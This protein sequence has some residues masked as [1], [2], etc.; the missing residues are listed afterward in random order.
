MIRIENIS[1]QLSHRILFI[2]A[3]AALNRGEKIGLVGPNGAGKTSLFRMIIGHELPDEGQVSV[4]KGVSIGYFNQDV[5]EMSGRSAVAEVMDGAGPVS[6]V[7]AELRELEAAMVDPDRMDEMD[8]IIERY[9]EVQA[10]YEELDGYA[11]DGRAREVLAGLSFSEAMMDGDVGAL[12]GGWKMRVALARILL[13]RPDVM[14]LDEPS[15]H[16]D[17]E[18]LIWLEQ[19]L[20]GYEGAL[21][22]TSHDREFMNR[23]VNKIIEIDAGQL[24]SYSGDYEFYEGQRAQNEKQ[25]QAQFERQQAMLA[26][27]IKFIERFKARA[28]HASQVQSRVKKLEKI[29]RVEPPKRRQV[30]AFEFQP[31]PRSGEDVVAVK[32]VSKRYGDKVIYDGFDFMVRRKERWCIMGINGAGKSTLLKLVAGDSKPDEGTVSIGASVK[33]GYFAQH[34]MDVLD[35]EMTIF[36]MLETT[37]PRAGQAPLRALAGC[38]G[39]SGDDIDKRVRVLSG[40]EKARLVMAIM[41]FDPPNLLVL[42][43]PT[44]HLDLDTKEMLIKALSQFEG[45]ML[46]VSHD[47]HFLA[48]L[49]NRVLEITQDG[50]FQYGGGYTEYVERTGHE[51]P[52]LRG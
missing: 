51:A 13:M 40:G 21:L 49:S 48:A 8:A 6:E 2:E 20:K 9:G 43:E 46:F 19:F 31:A 24:N 34:A 7:A 30:V 29:D 5:G 52:G 36:E 14:L 22:M 28:S 41:L 39:F 44:N 27:E 17:L 16:L 10:R 45:T 50:V 23:I 37:F 15:N 1:K 32:N 18:S 35:G 25:Q 47:R 38:F 3:S 11:L 42:D 33:M 4:D 12:S 26:K